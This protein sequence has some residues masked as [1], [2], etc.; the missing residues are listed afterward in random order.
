M[1]ILEI[2]K[3]DQT[4]YNICVCTYNRTHVIELCLVAHACNPAL[5]KLKKKYKLQ[6]RIGYTASPAWTT[7]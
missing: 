4:E 3:L 6:A 2:C 7:W 5:G 1:S